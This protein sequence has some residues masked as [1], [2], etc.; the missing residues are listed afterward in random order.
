[1]TTLPNGLRVVTETMPDARS[2]AVGCWVA[3]GNR[4]EPENMAGASHF[5]EHLLFKGTR[6][7][8]ARDIAEAV[9][10]T[11]GDM[12]AFT[13]KEY[14]AFYL[15]VPATDRALALDILCDVVAAPALRPADVESERD[16]ILEELHLQ[17]DEPDD[18]VHTE[19]AS[20][21]FPGHSLGWEILGTEETITSMGADAIRSFHE[22]WY[23][24][25]NLVVAAAGP[26]EHHQ[27]V[28]AVA[29]LFG[30]TDG[31]QAPERVAPLTAPVLHRVV[32]RKVESVHV[33]LGWLAFGH[34]DPERHALA[35]LNQILGAGMSSRLFQEV[36][37]ERGLA[38][39][40]FSSVATYEDAG[41]LSIYAGT[42]K[43]RV[44]EL[45][46]V[47]RAQIT[48]IAAH[49]VNANELR[50]AKSAFAGST[51]IN[52]EDTGNRMVRLA[53]SVTLRNTVT[54]I[55]EY[56]SAV[57]AIDRGAVARVAA[58]VLSVEPTL[59]AVGPVRERDVSW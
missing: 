17:L 7:R 2:I 14:T 54:P 18:L 56:L 33:A 31:G 1:M 59:A 47:I 40:V 6:S 3:V 46:D 19:L 45:L 11:G 29:A 21:M 15:R 22:H 41:V 50:V 58:R 38:Y 55:D 43:T 49:G 27:I 34:H 39:S 13:T 5:C 25:A 44:R 4:D 16:V 8:S 48:E 37:E 10:A 35:V 24:P 30:H 52:L 20:A 26:I 57:D 42:A 36:R 9:D 23:R 28:D 53:T 12:N 51:I 32:P